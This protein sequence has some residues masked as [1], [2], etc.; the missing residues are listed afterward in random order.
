MRLGGFCVARRSPLG[1]TPVGGE[2][3]RIGIPQQSSDQLTD[4][5]RAGLDNRVDSK[6][7]R[8]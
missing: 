6:P 8:P 2:L 5:V 1:S 4:L 7:S 3:D